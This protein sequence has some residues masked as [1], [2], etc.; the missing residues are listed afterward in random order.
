M[1]SFGNMNISEKC[2]MERKYE[3][4]HINSSDVKAERECMDI[5]KRRTHQNTGT[6]CSV[7]RLF[8][9]NNK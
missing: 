2:G 1:S 6:D 4:M 5:Q 7:L 8:Y 9:H 3:E